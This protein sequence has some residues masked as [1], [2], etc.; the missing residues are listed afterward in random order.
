VSEVWSAPWATL[1]KAQFPRNFPPREKGIG[2]AKTPSGEDSTPSIRDLSALKI[3]ARSAA[4][5]T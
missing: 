3:R 2:P 5:R 1:Q 4:F